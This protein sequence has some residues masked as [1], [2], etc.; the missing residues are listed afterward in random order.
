MA[1]PPE[2]PL[3]PGHREPTTVARS[4]RRTRSS[5]SGAALDPEG[6]EPCRVRGEEATLVL[7]GPDY[8][9]THK[10]WVR[11]ADGRDAIVGGSQVER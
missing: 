2:T 10:A 8:D 7:W 5:A 11:F 4:G 9:G 1:L 6:S 3:H